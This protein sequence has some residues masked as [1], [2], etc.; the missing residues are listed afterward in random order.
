MGVLGLDHVTIKSERMAETRAFFIEV[1]GLEEGWRPDLSSKG[2][3]LYAGGRPVLH[4]VEV[5]AKLPPGAERPSNGLAAPP[6]DGGLDHFSFA[7]ANMDEVL[8]RL[9]ARLILYRHIESANDLGRQ[10]FFR[11]P[12]GVQIELTWLKRGRPA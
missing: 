4:L 12:N 10:V 6:P 9:D 1:L 5:S 11:D 7:I 3:W 2:H 8:K